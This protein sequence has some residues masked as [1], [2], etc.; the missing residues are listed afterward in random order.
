M[1]ILCYGDSNTWGHDPQSGNR[2]DETIRW[3]KLLQ[4]M[5]PQ[6]EIIEH[7]LCGRCAAFMDSVKPYRHGISSLRETL[8]IYQPLDVVILMLGTN[9]LKACFSPNAVAISKGIKEM[10][11]II[12]NKANYNEHMNVPKILII[13]PIHIGE[14][15]QKIPRTTEQFNQN[16]YETAKKLSIYYEEIAKQYHCAFLDAA[17]YAKA[18]TIDAIHMDARNHQKLAQAIHSKLSDL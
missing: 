1:K 7:G 15:Y 5:H 12:L 3:T 10:V 4:Q 2:F 6:D 9:D 17:L 11:Q 8:E 13:A 16:S 14:G 18:S